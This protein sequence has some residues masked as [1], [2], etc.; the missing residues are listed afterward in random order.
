MVDRKRIPAFWLIVSLLASMALSLAGLVFVRWL[1]PAPWLHANNEVAGN[2]LQTL[3]TIYAVLLAFV[4]FVVWQQ[5][6]DMRG[7]L[8]N[9][10]NEL[11]DLDRIMQAFP[12]TSQARLRACVSAY[13][14]AVVG[15]EWT[16]MAHGRASKAAEQALED[17]WRVL[18]VFAPGTAR[19]EVLY[20]Q[21]LARFD[22]LSN[23]RSHRLHCSRL[24]LPPTLWLLL[25]TN[26]GL[27]TGSMWLF[28]LESFWA[29]ALMTAALT[30]S[31]AFVLYLI[32]DLDNPF[33][34][35]WRVST[36]PFHQALARR[37]SAEA[38]RHG[39]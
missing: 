6:N 22:D 35:S 12:E 32:A 30:G 5:H 7:A 25:L 15:E 39:R 33:W 14:Q 17:I 38:S 2:Y 1:A 27:V 19:E 36:E 13:C 34:G 8:E 16:A 23:A 26:G 29:H 31:I 10:A 28:G 18:A 11:S 9:E 24:R 21:A 20:A 4:V 37:Q 3:G